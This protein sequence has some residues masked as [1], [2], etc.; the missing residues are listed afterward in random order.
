MKQEPQNVISRFQICMLA[1]L[2]PSLVAADWKYKSRPDFAVLTLNITTSAAEELSL[3]YI[4]IALYSGVSW[5]ETTAH[6][7][8]QPA[9]Y[10]FTSSGELVWSGF[11]YFSGWSTNFQAAKWRGQDVLFAFEGSRNTLQ[12]HSHG[13]AK[14]LNKNYETI[15][16][17]RSGNHDL[18]DLHEFHIVDEKTAVM[19]SYHPLPYDLR[20]YGTKPDSQWI[21][22]ARFQGEILSTSYNF[23]SDNTSRT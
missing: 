2:F 3:G 14:I 19:E 11:G 7:P 18:L 8:L 22:D 21:V 16:E 6:G 12:G 20:P 15:R 5:S 23:L 1:L 17:I 9:P 10:I 4:F 13:H